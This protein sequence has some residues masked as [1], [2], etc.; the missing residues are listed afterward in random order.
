MKVSLAPA[1]AADA[2]ALLE[3]REAFV[4]EVGY[5]FGT[6]R[7]EDG[8]WEVPVELR[9]TG[10]GLESYTVRVDGE[11]I[12]LVDLVRPGTGPGTL[13]NLFV[14][15]EHRRRGIGSAAV[16][17]VREEMVGDWLLRVPVGL[18]P[19]VGFVD[20]LVLQAGVGS[21]REASTESGPAGTLRTSL[22][23]PGR[24]VPAPAPDKGGDGCFWFL[25]GGLLD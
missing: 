16:G 6:K 23:R 8:G 19:A 25:L 10:E 15:P 3:L 4:R 9:G 12:G 17:L 18:P 13:L 22:L 1:T 14:A 21:L 7:R 11:A 20:D 24:S 2:P 5:H